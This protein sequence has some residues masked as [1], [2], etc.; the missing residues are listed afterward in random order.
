MCA[1]AN[2]RIQMAVF[3]RVLKIGGVNVCILPVTSASTNILLVGGTTAVPPPPPLEVEV[4]YHGEYNGTG[5]CPWYSTMRAPSS[6][7]FA[8]TYYLVYRSGDMP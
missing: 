6:I 4:L 8:F 3:F 7:S 1:Q 5:F 2:A